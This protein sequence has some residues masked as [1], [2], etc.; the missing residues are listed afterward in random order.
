MMHPDELGEGFQLL[1]YLLQRPAGHDF[2]FIL[3]EQVGIVVIR[4][5]ITDF[6]SWQ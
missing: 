3:Q 2:L 4:L 5:T 6:R 1:F